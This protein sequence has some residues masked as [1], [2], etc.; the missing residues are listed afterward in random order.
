MEP[1]S[2]SDYVG[3]RNCQETSRLGGRQFLLVAVYLVLCKNNSELCRH[4]VD[5]CFSMESQSV[6]TL[7]NG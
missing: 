2:L 7:C 5:N 6:F 3:V 4:D 1:I